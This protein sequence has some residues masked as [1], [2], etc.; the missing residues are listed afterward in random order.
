MQ[1]TNILIGLDLGQ[2]NDYTVV[3]ILKVLENPRIRGTLYHLIYLY[4]VPLETSYPNII[5]WISAMVS[6]HLENYNYVMV[7]DY[8]GVGRPIVDMLRQDKINLLAVNITGGNAATWKYGNEVSVP[9]KEIVTSL[10]VTL[11]SSRLR[12]SENVSS[13]DTLAQ[14]FISFKPKISPSANLQFEAEYGYH[15]DIVMSIGL[16]IWYGEYRTRKSRKLRI[17]TGD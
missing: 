15:D 17:I 8:T 9:K 5:S 10:Q 6:D 3:S 11:E 4:R 2:Q 12:F 16:A 1:K 13:L 7:V 14:E